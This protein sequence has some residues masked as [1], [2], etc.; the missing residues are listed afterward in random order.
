MKK[1]KW[2]LVLLVIM[3]VMPTYTVNAKS[4]KEIHKLKF[5]DIET[6]MMERNPT[7]EINKNTRKNFIDSR[8]AIRDVEDDKEDLKDAIA[9]INKAI[10]FFNQAIKNQDTLM[11][12]LVE[13]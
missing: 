8:D 4:K 9:E 7:I 12:D 10:S 6:L 3:L 2:L 13:A 1:N 5:E 11:K